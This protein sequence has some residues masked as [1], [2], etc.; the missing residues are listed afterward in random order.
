MKYHE[1][2]THTAENVVL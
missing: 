1:L 2:R